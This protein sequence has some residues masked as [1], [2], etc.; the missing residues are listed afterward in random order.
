MRTLLIPFFVFIIANNIIGQVKMNEIKI[1]HLT[2]DF[3]VYITY[4][5]YNGQSFP[6]NSMYM[7]TSKGV[8]MFDTPW[9]S[10]QFQPLSDSILIRHN[11]KVVLCIS[12]HYHTDRTA[13]L[14]FL[15][16]RGVKTYTS[17]LTTSLCKEHNEK[18]A[19]FYFVK[20][21]TFT[22]GNHQFE[23]YYAGEGH[24]KDNIVIWFKKEKI[25][26][27]GCLIKSIEANDLG[28]IADAN[29]N[30]WNQTIK[31][32]TRKYPHPKFIIPGHFSWEGGK[33]QLK[34]TLKLLQQNKK[35]TT[36]PH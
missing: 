3:Y 10:T 17:L 9:D 24:T 31:N 23:T 33:K 34:H 7:V 13:G 18:Q 27:G 36:P 2:G 21:T 6:S 19:E 29:L 12:T 32:L 8:V 14:E 1:S 22:V 26:Y 15:K 28:N 5:D 30:D 20:D 25:L 35:T 4:K 11:K 16:K